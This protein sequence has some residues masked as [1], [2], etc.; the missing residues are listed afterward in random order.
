MTLPSTDVDNYRPCAGICLFNARGQV[1][2]GRRVDAPPP[3][4]WQ[5]PQGGI[6]AGE[7]PLFGAIR[8]LEE[9]TGIDVNLI[10]P[11]GEIE[12]WL[13][14]DIPPDNKRRHDR[15]H[16]QKQR[17][18]AFR[19]HGGDND[20]NLNHQSPAEFTRWKWASLSEAC[21]LIVPFKRDIYDRLATDFAHLE[22]TP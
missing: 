1:W 9:E 10:S 8:E 13:Y 6:D 17:W 16:G 7:N 20:I 12:D 4:C 15:W 21:T 11:L 3:Y 14:Y 19:Y 22:S 18:Y 2:M 5:F